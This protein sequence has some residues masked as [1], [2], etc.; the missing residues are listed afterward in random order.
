MSD[1]ERNAVDNLM[2]LCPNHHREIDRL[3]PQDWPADRL[4][5]VKYEHEQKCSGEQWASDALLEHFSSVLASSEA[6][7]G[8]SEGTSAPSP[9]L[10]VQTGENNS[11]FVVNVSEADAFNVSVAGPTGNDGQ[12]LLRLE[13]DVIARLS[14]GGRWHAG[15]HIKTFGNAGPTAVRVI[16]SDASGRTYDADFPL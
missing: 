14:P 11:I 3:Q 8:A 5:R 4:M 16:W 2:L 15:F 6:E 7:G 10:V 12:S 13:E 9:R 1:G